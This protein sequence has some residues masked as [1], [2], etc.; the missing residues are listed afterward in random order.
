MDLYSPITKL[1][2]IGPTRA[3][4]LAGMGIE[5]VYDLIAYFPRAYEDRT[6]MV[7][8]C[9]LEVDQPACFEGIVV[10]S[11]STAHIRK[12]LSLTKLTV[13]DLTGKL[14]IVYFNQPYMAD[15]LH[16]GQTYIFYGTVTGDYAGYQMQNPVCESADQ[17]GVVTRRIMPIYSLT[18]G[19]SNKLLSRCIHQA[20]DA[21]LADLPELLPASVLQRFGSGRADALQTCDRGV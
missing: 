8:I 14:N 5:T 17:P 11:P 15:N 4:Q 18:A 16:Y 1:A 21:C 2:G 20:L 10:R 19:I 9:Q 12:G 13:A 7:P 6:K 3:K